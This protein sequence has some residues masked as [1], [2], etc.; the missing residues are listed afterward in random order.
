MGLIMDY[1]LAKKLKDVGFIQ[2]G[3]GRF[4][5]LASTTLVLETETSTN[6]NVKWLKTY[7]STL[8][9]LIEACGDKFLC[10]NKYENNNV[11]RGTWQA[12]SVSEAGWKWGKRGEGSTPESAVANLWLALNQHD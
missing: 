11:K 6:N 5:C 3:K 1:E 9:E 4:Y 7:I 8:S 10:L 2:K 12:G